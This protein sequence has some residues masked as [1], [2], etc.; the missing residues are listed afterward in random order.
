MKPAASVAK[1][2]N[3]LPDHGQKRQDK[4]AEKR[5]H[6]T[7]ETF[8]ATIDGSAEDAQAEHKKDRRDRRAAW[9]LLVVHFG[10]EEADQAT[11]LEDAGGGDSRCPWPS[12]RHRA[13]LRPSRAP[14]PQRAHR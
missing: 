6:R 1:Q 2:A 12:W 3:R 9:G 14:A 5:H 4:A 11:P 13:S 8:Q 10:I 7:P